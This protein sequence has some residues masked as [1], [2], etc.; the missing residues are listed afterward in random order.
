MVEVHVWMRGV[1]DLGLPLAEV[2]LDDAVD[3]DVRQRVEAH[4][5]QVEMDVL[6]DAEHLRGRLRLV[7]LLGTGGVVARVLGRAAVREADDGDGVSAIGVEG[8]RAAHAEHLV[9][10]MRRED[11]DV[12]PS[13]SPTAIG[14]SGSISSRRRP[15][16]PHATTAPS[17]RSSTTVP[18]GSP[19]SSST[20]RARQTTSFSSP[21]YVNAPG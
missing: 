13:L 4:V 14:R 8:D 6:G 7:V 1:D 18:A 11:E 16:S 15:P 5:G 10:G 19:V 3:V 12:H 20:G 9:V 21:R 2:L 17:G